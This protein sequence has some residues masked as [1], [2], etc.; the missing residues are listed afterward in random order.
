LKAAF[1]KLPGQVELREMDDP[2]PQ[3][4]QVLVR[5][6]ASGICGS[7]DFT[8]RTFSGQEPA[9]RPGVPERPGGEVLRLQIAHAQR[10]KQ[11]RARKPED[12]PEG[13]PARLSTD[14]DC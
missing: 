11:K 8:Y 7:D 3:A 4:G 6:L 1:F 9:A 12:P 2:R 14:G 5:I 13:V 10:A